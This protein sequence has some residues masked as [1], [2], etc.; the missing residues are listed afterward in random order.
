MIHPDTVIGDHAA[1]PIRPG[2][3]DVTIDTVGHWRRGDIMRRESF[4]QPVL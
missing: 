3:N 1:A 2:G 4:D